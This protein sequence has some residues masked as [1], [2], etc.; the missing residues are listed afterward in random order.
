[1]KKPYTKP[2]VYAESFYLMDHIAAT[3]TF[4]AHHLKEENC[5]FT[6]AGITM[7]ATASACSADA[8]NM[9]EFAKVPLESRTPWNLNL[10][11]LG[12]EAYPCYNSFQDYNQLWSS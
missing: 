3:C 5:S 11:G 2:T 9:W 1:M 7:F 8:A 10:I 6:D 12:P 4:Q